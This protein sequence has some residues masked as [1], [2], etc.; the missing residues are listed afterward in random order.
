MFRSPEATQGVSETRVDTTSRPTFR[1]PEITVPIGVGMHL[2]STSMTLVTLERRGPIAIITLD[3][4]DIRNAF[5]HQMAQALGAELAEVEDDPELR[6]AILAATVTEP[7]PVFCA[8]H[9]LR[10]IEDERNGCARAETETGGF[11]GLTQLARTKP[12]IAAVDGLATSGGL[13]L[14]LS[15]D[16]VVATRRSSFELA[17]VR[18]GLI[19]GAGGLFRLPWAIGR[20][21]AM[22]MILTGQPID[23]ERAYALGLVSTLT[24]SDVMSAAIGRAELI[25]AHPATGI[26][27]S[28]FVATQAFSQSEDGL[29]AANNTAIDMI[30]HSDD[31]T[32][33]LASFAINGAPRPTDN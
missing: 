12:L 8:G 25:A 24:D 1:R 13:E 4:P 2:L 3:R 10:T 33:G 30:M 20:A 22:D 31:L 19:A 14:V 32:A 15:C 5:D 7:R 18:W 23:A 29:W 17:E 11:G 6:V 26:T 21:T 16:L 9:D 28:M 27:A